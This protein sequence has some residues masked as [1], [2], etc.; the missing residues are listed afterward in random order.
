MNDLDAE[1]ITDIMFHQLSE[2]ERDFLLGNFTSNQAMLLVGNKNYRDEAITAYL[3][4]IQFLEKLDK[5]HNQTVCKQDTI[6]H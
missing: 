6:T 1:Q 4:Y 2:D 3:S 5:L